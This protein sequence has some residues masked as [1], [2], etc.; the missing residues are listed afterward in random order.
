MKKTE[1]ITVVA[2]KMGIS[3]KNSTEIVET[4]I[5]TMKNGLVEDKVL[6]I[7]GFFKMQ[8]V[9]K[10]EQ[11]KK[12]TLGE[13]KGEEYVIPAHSVPKAKFSK[14]IKDAVYNG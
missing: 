10:A 9:H 11:V 6:D 2:E 5:D 13:N 8:I 7:N 3:K 1:L 12:Y 4:V 14:A